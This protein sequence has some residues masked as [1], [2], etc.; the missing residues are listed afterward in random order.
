[1]CLCAVMRFRS[2]V[3]SNFVPFAGKLSPVIENIAEIS[4][5]VNKISKCILCEICKISE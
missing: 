5:Q 2:S 1:M 3:L 4:L